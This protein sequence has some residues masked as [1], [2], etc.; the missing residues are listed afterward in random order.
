MIIRWPKTTKTPFQCWIL[1]TMTVRSRLKHWERRSNNYFLANNK[2]KYY[3]RTKNNF[4]IHVILVTVFP[5][6]STMFNVQKFWKTQSAM[7]SFIFKHMHINCCSECNKN[8]FHAE[9][10]QENLSNCWCAS[11]DV[12]WWANGRAHRMWKTLAHVWQTK[13][14]YVET[15]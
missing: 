14:K 3:P 11:P 9:L 6:F 7:Q 4:T 12:M 8:I 15:G 1:A 5:L 10:L 13:L 2:V